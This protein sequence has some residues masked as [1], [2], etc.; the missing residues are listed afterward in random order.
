MNKKFDPKNTVYLIDGSTYLYRA[1]FSMRPLHTSKGV[2]VQAVYSFI[3]MIG[4][5]M[6]M[7]QPE[8]MVLVWDSKGRTERKEIFE[9]YKA[10]RQE[11]P[12]DL[13]QQKEKIIEFADLIGLKQVAQVGVEADDIIGSLA[14]DLSSQGLDVV[15]IA[16]DKDLYQLLNDKI[17]ICDP[18][19]DE[20]CDKAK[21][22]EKRGFSVDRLPFY[23]ALL[24]DSS[25]N[26]PGVK[27]IGKKTA[28]DLVKQFAGLEELYQNIDNINN[29]RAKTALQENKENAFLSLQLFLLRYHSFGLQVD[30]VLFKA[31]SW[32]NANPLFE[33][34]EFQALLKGSSKPTTNKA[35]QES[36]EPFFKKKGYDF[37]CVTKIEE[38]KDLCSQLKQSKIFAVDTETTGVNPLADKMVGMSI[39]SGQGKSYYI[40]FGHQVAEEQLSFEDVAKELKPILEDG[41]I[42]KYLHN[43]KFDKL[44]F[45]AANINLQGLDMD[46]MVAAS[47]AI[48][49]WQR[50]G[51][52][53]LSEY[54]F[55][56]KMLTY[57]DVVKANKLK[58]F[59]QAPL[60]LATG[61]AASDAHQ[62]FALAKKLKSELTGKDLELYQRME[63]PLLDVLYD[64]EL[65]GIS[66]DT[67]IL[68]N[69]DVQVSADL[70]K[71]ETEIRTLTGADEINLNSPKQVEDLLFNQL[72]LPPQKKSGKGTS[73]STDSSVLE[74]LSN[75][76]P[77][78]GLI[79]RYRELQKLKNTYID[80]LP[81]YVNATT[82]KIH[83]TFSQVKTA[84]GR[85]SSSSPNLQ[86]IP[87]D[88][89]GIRAAFKPNDGDCFISADYSQIELRVLAY[90]SQDPALLS[91]F[92][93]NDDIHA[94]TASKLFG[95]AREDVATAQRQIGKRINF[96]IMYGLTPYGLSKDLKIPFKDA[97]LYI[98]KFFEQYPKI[99]EWME[100]TV[101]K[102]KETGYVETLWGRKRYVPEI[103]EANKSKFE[104]ARRLVINTPV[105]G[106]AADIMKLGMINLHKKLQSQNLQNDAKI[107]LQI[108]DE[109]LLSTKQELAGN[110]SSLV[111]STLENVVLWNVPLTVSVK[112]GKD[113]Q[114]VSK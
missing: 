94:I 23:H 89:F 40:P 111:K 93:R 86:N 12:T 46:T 54:Y 19:K 78:P 107:I 63:G 8:R 10:G 28:E 96:S 53:N 25:D 41:S 87:L 16:S 57:D 30:D 22:E 7:F 81:N 88:K 44:V 42:K 39:C 61:Y 91:A 114:E 36:I 5:L 60:S 29:S 31:E 55:D 103:N 65:E 71:I 32:T 38:L 47:L 34:L 6:K 112:S 106:T 98:E 102:A 84:T 74:E 17:F 85:L 4:K 64:M 110:I 13:F 48:K 79:L 95:V 82:K 92:E 59:S 18:F 37:K 97:K 49:D 51:L 72:N 26:I 45:H 104:M 109:L 73:Y 1:Y 2:P 43:V 70:E 69:I 15:I 35:K 3:R 62:T 21:F 90:L 80:A 24:G 76:H 113:W 83:T 99:S 75:I 14:K 9:D 58:D 100:K 52:K 66:I 68:K 77:V 56:E 20:T 27:G 108:H 101:E 33:E 67:S 105:Q 50:L 11:P